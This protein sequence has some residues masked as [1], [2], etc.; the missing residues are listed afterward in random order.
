M[1]SNLKTLSILKYSYIIPKLEEKHNHIIF[2]EK[3]STYYIGKALKIWVRKGAAKQSSRTL[4]YALIYAHLSL[5]SGYII[6]IIFRA[7]KLLQISWRAFASQI[8]TKYGK[9]G[10]CLLYSTSLTSK[11]KTSPKQL[12][13]KQVP[14]NIST[15]SPLL[16]PEFS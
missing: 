14:K 2:S 4:L 10:K 7:S 11:M 5:G 9:P 16:F 3:Y 12:K 8:K 6:T 13:R 15:L 1:T